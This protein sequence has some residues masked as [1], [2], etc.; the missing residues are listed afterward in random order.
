MR[1]AKI[2]VVC[3]CAIVSESSAKYDPTKITK[4]DLENLE[5][6]DSDLYSLAK[7]PN[8]PKNL[9]EIF[10]FI[11]S[12]REIKIQPLAERFNFDLVGFMGGR[13]R[14][15]LYGVQ[16][17]S[18]FDY[19]LNPYGYIGFQSTLKIIDPKEARQKKEEILKQRKEI[20]K[21][22]EMFLE[23]E[24]EIHALREKLEL[25]QLKENLYKIRVGE[26]VEYR[27]VRIENLEEML[28]TKQNLA[29][30]KIDLESKREEILDLVRAE[31]RDSLKEILK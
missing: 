21:H 10:E 9:N 17:P 12:N 8:K 30:V 26:G 2:L 25:L 13:N 6:L 28:K 20:L 7:R 5:R 16:S 29:K 22:I 19:M 18:D 3:F 11:W 31:S 1:K 27:S 24:H 14:S 15:G 4:Q 23:K